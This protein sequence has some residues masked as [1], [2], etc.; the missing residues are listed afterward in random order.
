MALW[1]STVKTRL[2]LMGHFKAMSDLAVATATDAGGLGVLASLNQ[3]SFPRMIESLDLATAAL[4]NGLVCEPVAPPKCYVDGGPDLDPGK[5][6]RIL[7][8]YGQ[9]R[10]LFLRR[11]GDDAR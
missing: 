3:A 5:P 11:P 7:P 9:V 4:Q 8:F 6:S 1:N 10:P 2:E